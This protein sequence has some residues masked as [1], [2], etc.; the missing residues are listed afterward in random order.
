[1]QI[2]VKRRG[3]SGPSVRG[4]SGGIYSD[5]GGTD[6]GVRARCRVGGLV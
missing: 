6:S 5:V 2:V 4:I 1:M 3:G